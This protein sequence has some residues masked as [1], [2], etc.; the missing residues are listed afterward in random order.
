[1][2]H[3]LVVDDDLELS[4]AVSSVLE[5]EGHTTTMARDGSEGLAALGSGT[6]DLVI[7]D[8]KMPI[9]DGR[10]FLKNMSQT[11]RF[12]SIPAI[13]LSGED[14]PAGVDAFLLKKPFDVDQLS[15][16][17]KRALQRPPRLAPD[18]PQGA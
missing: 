17:V 16:S 6:V 18:D 2:A 15:A 1:M 5:M 12:R 8:L 3:I 7:T 14:H 11:P 10:A 9:C 13:V 4:C